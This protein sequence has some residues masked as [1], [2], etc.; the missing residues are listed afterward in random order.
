MGTTPKDPEPCIS[1]YTHIHL[2]MFA[3]YR[4]VFGILL[5]VF[6]NRPGP[7]QASVMALSTAQ[8][9]VT[10]ELAILTWVCRALGVRGTS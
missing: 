8:A 4:T 10:W 7:A 3:I 1:L 6:S 5:H 2:F 9:G